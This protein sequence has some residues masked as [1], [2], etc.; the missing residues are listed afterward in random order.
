MV[1]ND[2]PNCSVSRILM[3]P[4]PSFSN[5]SENFLLQKLLKTY[6]KSYCEILALQKWKSNTPNRLYKILIDTKNKY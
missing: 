3:N 2:K 4:R 1:L 5:R 6:I